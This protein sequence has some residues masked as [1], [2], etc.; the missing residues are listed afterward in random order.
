VTEFPPHAL[1]AS[2]ALDVQETTTNGLD[3]AEAVVRLTR[4]GRNLIAPP[5]PVPWWRIL[6]AQ[7]RG[8][9][10]A[11]LFAALL[12]SAV[13]GDAADAIAIGAVLVL[14]V[15][16]G[17]VLE[18]RGRRAMESLRALDTPTAT[19]VRGGHARPVD[20]RDLV[21]GDI[22]QL[23]AGA[24][25]PAD[26]R[27]LSSAELRT[28]EAALTGESLP[29]AKRA[30]IVLAPDTVLAE[31]VNMV[32]KATAVVSG[33]ARGVVVG[34]GMQTEIGHVGT[35][36]ASIGDAPT[37]LERRLQ[38]LG[39]RL[40]V[41]SISVG[42][43][44][45]A[46]DLLRRSPLTTV[47]QTGIAVAVAAVPEGL[48]A[49]VTMAMAIGIRRM[50][51]R[52][53]LIRRLPAV[54]SLGSATVICT[55]KTGTL[56]AGE[57]TVTQLSL[58]SG[59]VAVTGS[60]YE[61]GGDF[62]RGGA[63]V[64]AAT[65]PELELAL[66][67]GALCNRA[68]V[69]RVGD[70]WVVHGDP[71]EIALLVAAVKAGVDTAALVAS[72]PLIGEVP[73]TSERMLMA[74]FYRSP[75]GP[76][77]AM[78]KGAPARV[79]ERCRIDAA[80]RATIEARNAAM[81]DQGLRVL[82]L[83]HG[84]VA[85]ADEEALRDLSFAGLVGMTDPAAPGVVETIRRLGEAG[86]R[87]VMLTGDQRGTALAVARALGLTQGG[88]AVAD[89]R[90]V[91]R[92]SDA[93]LVTRLGDTSVFSRVSPE[94]KLRIVAALQRRG[95]LVAMLGDG[96]NDAAALKKADIGVAMGRRGTEVAKEAAGLVLT[97][98]RFATVAAAVEEGRVVF[99]NVRKFVFYLF[100]CNL[101]EIAV[102]VV[103]GL[104]SLPAPLSAL[105]ILWLNLITDTFP[106]FALA[107]EPADADVMR[108]PPRD[109]RSALLT[110]EMLQ[111]AL[112]YA[113]LITA[114]SLSAFTWA[115]FFAANSASHA[116][117]MAFMTLAFAQLFHLGNARSAE[118]VSSIA[119]ALANRWALAALVLGVALQVATGVIA[120]LS[121]A[122]GT[123]PLTP[124]EWMVALA[125]A[126]VPAGVGQGLRIARG[127]VTR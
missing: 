40:A 37:P 105:Q 65:L 19:V 98:D 9:V 67:I 89:G 14:N 123:S 27:L 42:V 102:L 75:A 23:D 109:P 114:S 87:T 39:R 52:N 45:A 61:P 84:G 38:V 106:A 85:A 13:T 22:I 107:L 101:A 25:V 125:F 99:D 126:V 33:S 124:R 115:L 20:A 81:A 71:T 127:G 10:V 55:D 68:G 16:L 46:I 74:T 49:V 72:W 63:K 30:D 86:I 2:R 76:I 12:V 90:E 7:F 64:T 32:Y 41:A 1:T 21:P 50:A 108:R 121:R 88:D 70:R 103:A 15:A 3:E 117:T 111:S 43:V 69:N 56:T 59:D 100:S 48:P 28:A 58:P 51:K 44:V 53:A 66:R 24:N 18:L 113:A 77:V 35:L 120:P 79:L 34:T 80:A 47:I 17:F 78:A 62:R 95:E 122:L 112:F 119:R 104:L 91:D 110:R 57:Q 73:F 94:A 60:G 31:R 36:V 97:D 11:L 116:P 92:M 8:V 6:A 82:A 54:E 26:A 96:V 4:V 83:A 5:P 118:H 93:A 29:V